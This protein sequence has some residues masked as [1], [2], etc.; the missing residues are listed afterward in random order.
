MLEA[1]EPQEQIHTKWIQTR[2]DLSKSYKT[3]LLAT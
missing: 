2:K 1:N 3:V